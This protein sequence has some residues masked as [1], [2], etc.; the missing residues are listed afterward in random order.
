MTHFFKPLLAAATL[1]ATAITTPTATLADEWTP[2]GPI[3]MYVGFAA[4]GGADTQARLIAQG[5]EEKFGWTVIPQQAPGNSGLNLAAELAKAPADGTAIGMVVSETLSYSSQAAGDPAFD[6]ENFTSLATTAEFQLGLVAMA[7]GNFDSWDKVMGAAEAGTPIRFAAAS[8]R[9]ADMAWHLGQQVGIDFNIVEVRGGK[10]VMDGLR[11]GDVDIGWV[12]GAQS[13]PVQQGEMVNI[14]RGIESPLANSPD[15]PMIT[16]LG[17]DYLLDGYFMFIAPG[18]LDPA[19]REA[20]GEAI[21]DVAEDS[22]T[23]ANGLL[24]KAFGGPAV[25]TGDDLDSYMTKANA[26][27]AE[28]IKA[29]SE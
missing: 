15:A 25:R 14:A 9:H 28:L 20:L 22:E 10:G 1:C 26:E 24:S 2:P 12:A 13:G 5:L 27:A 16:E 21:R 29:V 4:G 7:N 8:D 23:D 17:S 19:A 6:Y 3:T 18:D 11:G